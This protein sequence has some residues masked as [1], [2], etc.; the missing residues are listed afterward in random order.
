[1]TAEIH[2]IEEDYVRVIAPDD[3]QVDK[4]SLGLGHSVSPLLCGIELKRQSATWT[5]CSRLAHNEDFRCPLAGVSPLIEA[6]YWAFREKWSV[7]ARRVAV[8][9]EVRAY[10]LA[11]EPVHREPRELE[12]LEIAQSIVRSVIVA[13]AC[14]VALAEG[15]LR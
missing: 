14:A 6:E 1:M 3:F 11:L 9:S 15:D 4:P 10:I 7:F 13:Q 12:R 2:E 8:S 5:L